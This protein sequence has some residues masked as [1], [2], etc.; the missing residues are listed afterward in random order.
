M[1]FFWNVRGLNNPNKQY[2]LKNTLSKFTG[3]IICLLETH[4]R[5]DIQ[6]KVIQFLKPGRNYTDNY[7]FAE[8]GR[9]WV[10]FGPG[11]SL[12]VF[13]SSA[14]AIHCHVYSKQLQKYFFLTVVYASNNTIERRSL[15]QDLLDIKDIM[16]VVPWIAVGDFNVIRTMEESSDYFTGAPIASSTQE[17][18][19][20]L[21]SLDFLDM[22]YSG[23]F[24]TWSNKRSSGFIA[25]KLDRI[26][27]NPCWIQTFSDIEAEFIHLDSLIIV[28]DG[29]LATVQ[30]RELVPLNS[31]IF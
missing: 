10:L 30:C 23:P 22:P 25:K 6:R 1:L 24:F 18:S 12:S 14:Q 17:F 15:W 13:K 11:V 29:S 21:Q 27:I 26:L 3:D 31:S 4:V 9:I 2:Q 8:L 28:Q 5:K 20:C 7:S 16:P 19:Y